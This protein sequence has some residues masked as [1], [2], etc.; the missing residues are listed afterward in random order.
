MKF[1]VGDKM[2][3]MYIKGQI[4]KEYR[5]NGN[6]ISLNKVQHILREKEEGSDFVW[7]VESKLDKK[8]RLRECK[9]GWYLYLPE[10]NVKIQINQ[11]KPLIGDVCVFE[12]EVF[13][14]LIK[15]IEEGFEL[16][17]LTEIRIAAQNEEFLYN[18]LIPSFFFCTRPCI[19]KAKKSGRKE[20]RQDRN[21]K[22][23]RWADLSKGVQQVV[24]LVEFEDGHVEQVQPDR[25]IFCLVNE[26]VRTDG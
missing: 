10:P 18:Q 26:D 23:H 1:Y 6:I 7:N 11:Q 15:V 3:G 21:A 19:V 9:D 16:L 22:F 14:E 12:T 13:E 24:A 17:K 2:S 20:E 4:I 8:I 5:D 25:V